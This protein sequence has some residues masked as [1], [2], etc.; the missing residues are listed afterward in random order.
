[1]PHKSAASRN[2]GHYIAY[3]EGF[4]VIVALDYDCGTRAGW[5]D[6]HLGRAHQGRR[7]AGR[8]QPLVDNGWVNSI[9]M[10]FETAAVYARGFPYELRTPSSAAYE[11]TDRHRAR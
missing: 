5:L 2:V 8:G 3:K 9:D 1:M 6:A 10:T 11:Q 4:D 7:G